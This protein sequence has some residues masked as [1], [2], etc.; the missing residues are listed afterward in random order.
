M[1]K[2]TSCGA[3]LDADAAFC[4]HDGAPTI[5][6]ASA[7]AAQTLMALPFVEGMLHAGSQEAAQSRRQSVPPPAELDDPL[8]G[9]VLDGR[10]EITRV[11]GQGAMGIVYEAQHIKLGKRVAIK[12]LR[13][14]MLVEENVAWRFFQ[15][16]QACSSIGHPNIVDVTD[17]GQS[18]DGTSY[19]VM[20]YLE[21]QTL[22]ERIERGP[23]AIAEAIAI[24]RQIASA[25]NAAHQKGIVHRDLKP[26]NIV[27]LPS[28]SGSSFV[29]I[30]DFGVA[31]VGEV[32]KATRPELVFGTPYYMAPEQADGRPVDL[33]TDIYALGT[34]LYEMLTGR[35][36]FD[37][38][39]VMELLSKQ[40]MEAPRPPI[41]LNP[42]I[43]EVNAV[44]LRALAK[45]PEERFQSMG[46]FL[47]ALTA[48][49]IR[50]SLIVPAPAQARRSEPPQRDLVKPL[51][52]L[53]ALGALMGL[54]LLGSAV[55]LA[56]S[57]VRPDS[58]PTDAQAVAAPPQPTDALAKGEPAASE[59]ATEAR[60]V[61]IE[62]VPEG[63]SVMQDGV[64]LGNTPFEIERP[65]PGGEELLELTHGELGSKTVKVTA[66]SPD[67]IRTEFAKPPARRASRPRPRAAPK[68]ASEKTTSH[69]AP[70]KPYNGE[71][72]DPWAN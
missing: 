60:K 19:F 35:T 4:P 68:A 69:K 65:K 5:F 25:L 22:G 50:P 61:R 13:E 34:I 42:R 11:I 37:A 64:V 9:I 55:A 44:I 45:A 66:S 62:T 38:P 21:G 8:V 63:V 47:E 58:E 39:T 56:L 33:R 51:T 29:K 10:H 28:V 14:R 57:W 52:W 43:G 67:T 40:L 12:V 20:E 31:Q 59:T 49:E 36:P 46:G 26:D 41:E 70:P 2:C 6:Q 54:A 17:F 15:E 27:L 32:A 71:F 16:A 48:A 1:R 7:K 18:P 72:L 3:E 53:Y 30:L 24:A 23:I